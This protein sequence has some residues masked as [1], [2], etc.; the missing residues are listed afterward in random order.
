M[1]K[2][3]QQIKLVCAAASARVKTLPMLHIDKN[4]TLAASIHASGV[5]FGCYFC[6]YA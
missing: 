5:L 2:N 4:L 6:S 3:I 1:S